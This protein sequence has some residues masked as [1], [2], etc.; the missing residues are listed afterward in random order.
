M[1]IKITV[2]MSTLKSKLRASGLTLQDAA[3]AVNNLVVNTVVSGINVEDRLAYALTSKPADV[4]LG[5]FVWAN[6]PEGH[7]YWAEIAGALENVDA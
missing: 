7:T 2:S 5:G 3:L 1:S 6:T 4:V